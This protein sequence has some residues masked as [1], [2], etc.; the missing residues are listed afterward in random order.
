[1][2]RV[3]KSREAA[4]VNPMGVPS[5]TYRDFSGIKQYVE[6][7]GYT[8]IDSTTFSDTPRS[9]ALAFNN[10]LG[11][12]AALLLPASGNRYN[13]KILHRLDTDA[14]TESSPSLVTFSAGSTLLPILDKH[15]ERLSFYGPHIRYV[16]AAENSDDPQNHEFYSQF[17]EAV[18]PPA[19]VMSFQIDNIL[20]GSQAGS[21]IPVVYEGSDNCNSTTQG[22][23]LPMFLQSL[24]YSAINDGSI[25]DAHDKILLL[26]AD[27]IS[28]DTAFASLSAIHKAINLARAKALCITAITP[29]HKTPSEH[30]SEEE[31]YSQEQAEHFIDKVRTLLN[32]EVP[33]SYGFPMGHGPYKATIPFN[34]PA[35]FNY[36]T[37]SLTFT[38]ESEHDE[39]RT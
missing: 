1:M 14:M 2:K 10:A 22:N 31:L 8:C 36:A 29:H 24:E 18:Q 37:N 11:A 35:S 6:D 21:M 26:E 38:I 20:P 4:L 12:R 5:N 33:V 7:H 34:H 15:S 32:G 16:Q 27:D 13:A 39:A 23:V 17:W 19:G 28:F 30:A 25:K 9:R 3:A